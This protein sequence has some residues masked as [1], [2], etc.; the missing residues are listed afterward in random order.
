MIVPLTQ[1]PTE[2]LRKPSAR[3]DKITPQITTLIS[4]M[5]ETLDFVGGVGL[6][7]PQIGKNIRLFITNYSKV[8]RIFI[9]PEIRVIDNSLVKEVEGCLSVPGKRGSTP[10]FKAVEVAYL[11]ENGNGKVYQATGFRA[12]IMQ[13]EIDH[14]EGKLYI[15]RVKSKKDLY[16]VPGARIVFFG[17]PD[18]G[19]IV[20]W[21]IIGHSWATKDEVVAVVTAPDTPS[22]RHQSLLPSPVKQV[23]EK[24]SIPALTPAKLKG[25]QHLIDKL[26]DLKPDLVVLAA[27]GKIV[28][29]EILEIPSKGSLNVHPSLLPKYRGPSPI[30]SVLL[31]G[32]KETGVTIIKMN[33]K[34]DAGE[35]LAQ[36]KFPIKPED[37]YE[38]LGLKLFNQGGNI[39]RQLISLWAEG[40]IK[41]QAQ[42]ETKATYTKI[43][44]KENGYFDL[45]QPPKNLKDMIRAYY[46]WPGVW[47]KF[48][49][50][51]IKFLPEG[52]VQLEGKN[53]VKIEDFRRGHPSLPVRL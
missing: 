22:G 6:A 3:I 13:H 14:L 52:F 46:P 30:Q 11:D 9:N 37:T 29:R 36:V 19:A 12:K 26:N 32:E 4:D 47:T 24:F 27:Y 53:P 45:K 31:N 39:L 8:P 48:E 33:E 23:A 20:L 21:H 40:E 28:P 16:S 18:F 5:I 35:I 34:V 49:G 7:A 25:N 42:D 41:P 1:L 44:K 43:I 2:S 15:D 38:S 10:R 17:T 50:K 51:I